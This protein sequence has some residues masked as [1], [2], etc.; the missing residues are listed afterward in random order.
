MASIDVAPF[1][2]PTS[3]FDDDDDIPLDESKQTNGDE[4]QDEAA[5]DQGLFGEGDEEEEEM[6]GQEKP[7]E[8]DD[9][10]LDSGDDEDRDDRV[11]DEQQDEQEQE[12]E[13]ILNREP[14]QIATHPLPEGSDG[15]VSKPF[16]E[17]Q[18]AFTYLW[19]SYISSK[20]LNSWRLSRTLS[21][22]LLSSLRRLITIP[23][24]RLL[25][26]FLLTRLR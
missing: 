5:S 26:N 7:R 14:A 1:E 17:L 16:S 19:A 13:R 9:E 23:K 4:G 22:P 3:N 18:S 24:F 12:P 21:Q 11:R 25:R 15:E 6:D 2:Q 20:S 10:E 8:L